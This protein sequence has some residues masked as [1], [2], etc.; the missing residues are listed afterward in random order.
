MTTLEIT[1]NSP[2]Y[3]LMEYSGLGRFA[4]IPGRLHIADIYA[5]QQV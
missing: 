4:G 3:T 5:V 2:N 1:Q